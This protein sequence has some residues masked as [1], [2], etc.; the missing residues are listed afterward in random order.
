MSGGPVDS[1]SFWGR[2]I[3]LTSKNITAGF[4]STKDYGKIMIKANS[5]GS[6]HIE[7][8]PSQQKKIKQ[9]KP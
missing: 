6:V 4:L 8:T 7:L 9:L 2:K 3:E 1:F 5:N